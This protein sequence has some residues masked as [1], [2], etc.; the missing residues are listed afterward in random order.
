MKKRIDLGFILK[1]AFLSVLL[2]ATVIG[3]SGGVDPNP[4][5]EPNPGT[6][7]NDVDFKVVETG[8]GSA[9]V[10]WNK[11]DIKDLS[12]WIVTPNEVSTSYEYEKYWAYKVDKQ[13]TAIVSGLKIGEENTIYLCGYDYNNGDYKLLKSYELKVTPKAKG[14]VTNLTA[15]YS[16]FF[17]YISISWDKIPN[18]AEI[19][20][21]VLSRKSQD[22]SDFVVIAEL[23]KENYYEDKSFQ[24]EKIYSY[25]VETFDLEGE[26][27]GITETLEP[28][29]T[30]ETQK[31]SQVKGVTKDT[32]YADGILI[33]W[34]SQP[35]IEKYVVTYAPYST[36]SDTTIIEVTEPC[37]FYRGEVLKTSSISKIADIYVTVYAVNEKGAGDASTRSNIYDYNK[38]LSCSGIASDVKDKTAKITVSTPLLFKEATVKYALLNSKTETDIYMDYQDSGVFELTDLTPSTAKSVYPIMKIDYTLMDGTEKSVTTVGSVINFTTTEP[39]GYPKKVTGFTQVKYINGAE[40]TWD[41]QENVTSYR[42][43]EFSSKSSSTPKN[44]NYFETTENSYFIANAPGDFNDFYYGV[45]AVN[46]L[47]VGKYSDIINVWFSTTVTC[48]SKVSEI[49]NTSAKV[50]ISAKYMD[51]PLQVKNGSVQYALSKNSSGTLLFCEYQDSDVV[52]VTGLEFASE[53]QLYGLVKITYNDNGSSKNKI[54]NTSSF[55]INTKSFEAPL[56]PVV[57]SVT[58]GS[59]TVSFTPLSEEQLCGIDASSVVYKVYAYKKGYSYS[60]ASIATEAGDVTPVKVSGLMSNT[61]YEFTVCAYV[62]GSSIYGDESE[63]VTAVT[64]NS[65]SKPVIKTLEEVSVTGVSSPLSVINVTF[66]PIV[67]DEDEDILYGLEWEIFEGSANSGKYTFKSDNAFS[68]VKDVAVIVNGGNRYFVT[69]YAYAAEDGDSSRVRSDNKEI[70]LASVDDSQMLMGLYYTE[71]AGAIAGNIVDITNSA[72]WSTGDSFTP[73]STSTTY[74]WGLLDRKGS[75]VVK[76]G[77]S[78]AMMKLSNSSVDLYYVQKYYSITSAKIGSTVL[79]SGTKTYFVAPNPECTELVC[80]ADYSTSYPSSNDPW[81]M[82]EYSSSGNLAYS[83][84]DKPTR[85]GVSMTTLEQY[86]FNNGLYLGIYN[87]STTG[88]SVGV[89]YRY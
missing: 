40:L 83:T 88:A 29:E 22:E 69:L 3:C 79:A 73:K 47:G 17:N 28:V 44:D 24:F 80:F 23:G 4:N 62:T 32:T 50:T 74:S 31:P 54:F 30:P 82:P 51:V 37:F 2:A 27:C 89:S 70:Q 36:P 20:K 34:N 65:L 76:F 46:E 53:T 58:R 66:D 55:K 26:S 57:D 15:H 48:T 75:Y 49:G 11:T 72:T 10:S 63:R 87:P 6:T 16:D 45:C 9:T 77:L 35:A 60:T 21:I 81:N 7:E 68:N 33:K 78:D 71:D 43:Y 59:A 1:A 86:M 84:L 67:E 52:D 42:I 8:L 41:A 12:F 13:F 38:T 14:P 64:K 85:K 5:P 56:A 18:E 39:E 19:S 61:E 25:K